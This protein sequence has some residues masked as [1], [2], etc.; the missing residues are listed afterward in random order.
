MVVGVV[1]AIFVFGYLVAIRFP[2]RIDVWDRSCT[3]FEDAKSLLR[4]QGSRRET[5]RIVKE[6]THRFRTV[7]KEADVRRVNECVKQYVSRRNG[8]V[9]GS[10][11][12]GG[13]AG[14]S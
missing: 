10:Y 1:V 7:V 5:G 3:H 14:R 12:G 4:G 6:R 8:G 2:D 13:G 11:G 9:G